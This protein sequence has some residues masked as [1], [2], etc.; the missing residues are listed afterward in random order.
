MVTAA[1]REIVLASRS[2]MLRGSFNTST[3]NGSGARK[4]AGSDVS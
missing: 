4:I 3:S 1:S 2:N